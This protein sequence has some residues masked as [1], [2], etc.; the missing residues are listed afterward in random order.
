MADFKEVLKTATKRYHEKQG[1]Y[2]AYAMAPW[3]DRNI[4]NAY[5][6][7]VN[8]ELDSASSEKST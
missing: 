8:A 7:K 5:L 6:E 2:P 1:D 3:D 4:W